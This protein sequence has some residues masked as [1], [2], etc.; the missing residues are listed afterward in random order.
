MPKT[1]LYD[2]EGNQVG[3]VDLSPDIFDVKV[4]EALMHDVV[5]MQLA[6]RRRGTAS[7]KT[8]GEVRGGGR[9]PWRQKGTGRARHGTIRSPLWIGGSVTFGP[10]PRSFAFNIPKKAKRLAIKSALTSKVKAGT[11]KVVDDLSL[12]EPKTREMFKILK[13]LNSGKK[14]LLVTSGQDT[15]VV[16]SARNIPGV[17]T[18]PAYKLNVYDILNCENLILTKEALERAEEVFA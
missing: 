10:K 5:L 2:T 1:S 9:K 13:K 4:N 17:K 7:T 11:L 15:N 14:V 16:K 3:E 6:N 12:E 18:L 8:R